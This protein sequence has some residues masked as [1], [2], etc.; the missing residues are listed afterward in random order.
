MATLN[1]RA[2]EIM[3]EVGVSTATDITGFGLIGHLNEV[4]TASKRTA[5]LHS[6][7]V[8]FFE[9]AV[10]LAGDGHGSRRHEG[11]PEKL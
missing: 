6:S 4:L 1:K 11:Q 7:A 10:T 9:E 5:R 3:I 2:G 8:P